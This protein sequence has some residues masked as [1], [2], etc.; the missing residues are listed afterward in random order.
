MESWRIV[1][2]KET[3]SHQVGFV[4]LAKWGTDDVCEAKEACRAKPL[5][6]ARQGLIQGYGPEQDFIARHRMD[7]T[8]DRPR[9][10]EGTRP[11]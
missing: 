4:L 9:W 1:L 7:I 2:V 10:A 8:G 5:V 6:F 11:H 3:M